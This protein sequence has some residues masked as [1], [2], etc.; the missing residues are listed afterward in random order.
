M[1]RIRTRPQRLPRLPPLSASGPIPTT[2]KKI[3]L[4]E[5]RVQG[6][7]AGGYG[8]FGYPTE[9]HPCTGC[10]RPG[11]KGGRSWED[12]AEAFWRNDCHGRAFRHGRCKPQRM[13]VYPRRDWPVFFFKSRAYPFDHSCNPF[14]Y[15]FDFLG[16]LP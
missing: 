4:K 7:I 13:D 15:L 11:Q 6:P 14:Y 8:Q 5:K 1:V 2:C 3:R 9:Y 12:G 16:P 10:K